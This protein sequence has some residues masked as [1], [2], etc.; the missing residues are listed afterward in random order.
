WVI[1]DGI[2]AFNPD[3]LSVV[4]SPQDLAALNPGHEKHF[5]EPQ[6][7]SVSAT[8]ALVLGDDARFRV[9]PGRWTAEPWEPVP[10]PPRLS[11]EAELSS[12][13]RLRFE[14]GAKA[15]TLVPGEGEPVP[16]D[17]AL[18]FR[19]GQFV[20]DARGGRVMAVGVPPSV[21]VV[22]RDGERLSR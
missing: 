2:W 18:E 20:H 9:T 7:V 4:Y 8:G 17:P 22:D 21:M 14:P 19:G 12:G 3:D 11:A 6:A 5:L 1:S 16:M 10:P 15:P 13:T